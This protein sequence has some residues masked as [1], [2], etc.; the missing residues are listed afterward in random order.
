[1]PSLQQT[2]IAVKKKFSK[3]NRLPKITD[4]LLRAQPKNGRGQSQ[5]TF[6]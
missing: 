5:K 2:A 3:Y 6:C 4:F 1:M